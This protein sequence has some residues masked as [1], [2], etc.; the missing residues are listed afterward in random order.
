MIKIRPQIMPKSAKFP[1]QNFVA[2]K[3]KSKVDISGEENGYFKI[4]N[5]IVK[6]IFP[7]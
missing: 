3:I 2:P 5:R 6:T 4:G 1:K 7:R